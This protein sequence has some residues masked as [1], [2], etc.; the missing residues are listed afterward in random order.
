MNRLAQANW[1][2]PVTVLARPL[3]ELPLPIFEW[4]PG[5]AEP[6]YSLLEDGCRERWEFPA[7]QTEVAV[8][9][10]RALDV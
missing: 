10:R 4:A 7:V 9:G 8:A 6:D 2:T 1:L 5:N 3:L